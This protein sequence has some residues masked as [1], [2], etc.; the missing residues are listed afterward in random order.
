MRVFALRCRTVATRLPACADPKRAL[1]RPRQS[2]SPVVGQ[3]QAAAGSRHVAAHGI[4][5][6]GRRRSVDRRHRPCRRRGVGPRRRRRS[7]DD[8]RTHRRHRRR[9]PLPIR[10]LRRPLGDRRHGSRLPP[11]HDR[12]RRRPAGRGADRD[13]AD[14][15]RRIRGTPRRDRA[16]AAPRGRSGGDSAAPEAGALDR[17]QPRQSVPH[18]ADAAGRCRHRRVRQQAVG[19]RRRA[20]PEPDADG[21]RGDSQPVSPVRPDERVQSGDGRTLRAAGGRLRRQVRR[22]AV[23][24]GPRREPGRGRQPALQRIVVGEHHRREHHRRRTAARSGAGNVARDG[25]PHVLRSRRG[26]VRRSGSAVVQRRADQDRVAASRQPSP[27]AARPAQPRGHQHH[28][29]RR[30]GRTRRDPIAQRSD[31]GDAGVSSGARLVHQHR[32]LVAEHR[33]HRHPGRRET[34]SAPGVGARIS[35]RASCRSTTCR[36]ARRS[37]FRHS[38]AIGWRPEPSGIVCRRM[39]RSRPSTIAIRSGCS[40]AARCGWAACFPS[41]STT[42]GA[43]RAAAPGSRIACSCRRRSRWFPGCGG[44]GAA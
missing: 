17:R 34:S 1:P 18:A 42:R 40:A 41:G 44:T 3:R 30:R 10:R 12:V 26:A 7:G 4:R 29:R 38:A 31:H 9:G 22:P 2:L 33:S 20:G 6:A 15:Q 27:V 25:A 32:R 8:R 11:A 35:S 39:S 19:P 24:R 14:S 13:P 5:H 16:G 43:P 28:S 21:R 37:G 23:V 36:C